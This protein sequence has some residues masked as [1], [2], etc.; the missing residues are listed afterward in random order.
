MQ[1]VI[2]GYPDQHFAVS[3]WPWRLPVSSRRADHAVAGMLIFGRAAGGPMASAPSAK[4]YESAAGRSL[5]PLAF[6]AYPEA[7]VLRSNGF[8]HLKERA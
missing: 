7:G 5:Q 8:I 1:R 4:G 2:L 6:K 3:C